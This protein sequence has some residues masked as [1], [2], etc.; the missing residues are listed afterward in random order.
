MKALALSIGFLTLQ[1]HAMKLDHSPVPDVLDLQ[2]E[3]QMS[4]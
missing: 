4:A 2:L 3:E 1:A